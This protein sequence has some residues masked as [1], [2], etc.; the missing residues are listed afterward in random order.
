MKK[1]TAFI[2]G[3]LSFI[4]FG[5]PL[6]LKS[7]LVLSSTGF[8][9]FVSETV[10]ARTYTSYLQE[11][12]D[13][14][15][16]KGFYREAIKLLYK[17]LSIKESSEGYFYLGHA[18]RSLEEFDNSINSFKKALQ[19]NP[20]NAVIYQNIGAVEGDLGNHESAIKYCSKAIELNSRYSLAYLCRGISNAKLLNHKKAIEDYNSAI[21][22]NPNLSLAYY[23]R[24]VS[25][26]NLQQKKSACE[27]WRKSL[28]LGYEGVINILDKCLKY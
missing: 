12:R 1:R 24:G 10:Y 28:K 17:S 19:F 20:N 25:K 2:G 15:I 7:T 13:F 9:I 11:A 4:S 14:L 27:D 6:L 5:Q 3:I 16:P 23:N 8:I 22:F 26:Y 21:I 18:Y